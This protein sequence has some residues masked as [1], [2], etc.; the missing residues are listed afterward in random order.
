VGVQDALV[1]NV[2][3][4]L[5]SQ[6]VARSD[7]SLM[8]CTPTIVS[9]W[10][11][12]WPS[13]LDTSPV[14]GPVHDSTHSWVCLV[15]LVVRRRCDSSFTLLPPENRV[16][17]SSHSEHRLPSVINEHSKYCSPVESKRE[18]LKATRG[19]SSLVQSPA[20]SLYAS[21]KAAES[22]VRSFKEMSLGSPNRLI[23]EYFVE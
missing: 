13:R 7:S 11:K 3:N 16:V 22:S 6:S 14:D 4:V 21:T 20:G 2:S 18:G 19:P 10:G 17:C 23:V 9:E 12:S 1:E 8:D 5:V 15:G